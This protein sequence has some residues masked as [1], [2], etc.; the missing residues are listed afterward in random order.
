MSDSKEAQTKIVSAFGQHKTE[1]DLGQQKIKVEAHNAATI[2]LS[3][4]KDNT[5]FLWKR[6]L[7]ASCVEN[8]CCLGL[9]SQFLTSVVQGFPWLKAAFHQ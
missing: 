4:L 1:T 8:G 6:V 7:E 2:L 9:L 3:C 5:L